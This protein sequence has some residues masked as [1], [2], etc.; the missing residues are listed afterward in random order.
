MYVRDE[1]MKGVAGLCGVCV[2]KGLSCVLG[3]H[4]DMGVEWEMGL[5]MTQ[6]WHQC[7]LGY[8]CVCEVL[9]V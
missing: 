1:G 7:V 3:R 2:D 8:V 5:L 4:G 9:G 6:R